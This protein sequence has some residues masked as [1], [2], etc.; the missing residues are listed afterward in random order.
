MDDRLYFR[1]LKAGRD[2]GQGNPVC[3]GMDNF[4]YLIG[5]RVTSE[6]LVVDPAWDVA[7][8]VNAA[9]AD[10]MKITGALVTHWHPDHVGGPLMNHKVEGLP[11]LL[12][13][14]PCKVHIHK[15]DVQFVKMMT[16]ISDSDIVAHDSGDKVKAGAIEVECLHTPGH[17]AGSQCFRCGD[18]LIAGDTLFLQGCGRLDLPGGS[19]EEMWRTLTERLSTIGDDVVLY[20]GHDYSGKSA[21]MGDVRRTNPILNAPDYASWRRMMGR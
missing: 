11:R 17:T 16:A 3:V 5:D 15:G 10:G 1:Q 2:F 9:A 13:L 19:V 7:S 6:C 21:P 20:P 12:E 8:I 18:K 14:A 4:I